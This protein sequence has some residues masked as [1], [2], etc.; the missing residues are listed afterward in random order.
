MHAIHDTPAHQEQADVEELNQIY[1]LPIGMA[2][3]E[4]TKWTQYIPFCP[5][6]VSKNERVDSL[7]DSY[8]DDKSATHSTKI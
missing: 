2:W 5:T 8:E 1:G 6:F 4:R 7:D 3:I